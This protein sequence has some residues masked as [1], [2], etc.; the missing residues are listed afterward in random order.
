MPERATLL[1]G[2]SDS[3]AS[4]VS[5]SPSPSRGQDKQ[6]RGIQAKHAINVEPVILDVHSCAH[7]AMRLAVCGNL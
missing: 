3:S 6:F 4:L 2:S 7:A 1:P 5:Y